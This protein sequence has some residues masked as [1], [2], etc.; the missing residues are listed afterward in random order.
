MLALIT[1]G[2]IFYWER[3]SA[4]D[5][6]SVLGTRAVKLSSRSNAKNV[7]AEAGQIFVSQTDRHL[8][9]FGATPYDATVQ[10]EDTGTFDPLLIRFSNQ[11][12]P[13]NFRPEL[14]NSA[15]FLKVSSGTR[16]VA[17]AKTRQEILVFT[18]ASVHSLQFLG[19]SEV[20]GLQELESNVSIAG[21][22]S[23]IS[24]SN[25]LFWM[26]TDKF[27][28]YDG[29]INTLPCSLRDHVFDNINFDALSYVYAGTIEAHNEVWWFYPSADSAIN[30]SYV[31]YNYK[32]RVWFY[33]SL[34][35]SAWL[36]LP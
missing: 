6:T 15:G 2:A 20:F 17:A 31:T 16:I 19:T 26:G 29:R 35:R 9:A 33:G 11:D 3:G 5:P 10:A 23:V 14:T 34:N 21:P 7:P 12:E 22:R 24:A 36:M 32:D 18:D 25:I 30:D 1:K 4:T 28:I 13:E 8:L 27:Y